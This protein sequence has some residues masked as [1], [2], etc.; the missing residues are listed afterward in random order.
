MWD[1]LTDRFTVVA[2][3]MLGMGF[4]DKPEKYEYTVHDHADMHEALLPISVWSLRTSSL[5]TSAT[6]SARRCW[7]ATS[8]AEQVYGS[9][10]IESITWLTAGCSTRHTP[11]GCCRRRCRELRWGTS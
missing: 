3:D 7:R 5:T 1:R 2:P 9:P 10:R 8:S 6:R 11:L 4:S